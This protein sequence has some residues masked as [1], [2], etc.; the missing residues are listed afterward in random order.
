[1]PTKRFTEFEMFTLAGQAMGKID[2]YGRRGAE[3]CTFDEIEAMALML[4]CLGLRPL[5][6]GE[7]LPK[8]AFE[9]PLAS[10]PHRGVIS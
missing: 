1:M 10:V 6:P 4:A 3:R 7:T 2:Q 8:M 9:A 5:K